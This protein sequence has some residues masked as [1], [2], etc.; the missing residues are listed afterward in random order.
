MIHDV[1]EYLLLRQQLL[2][3]T[4]VTEYRRA[5][6]IAQNIDYNNIPPNTD[7]LIK[8][9]LLKRKER[10]DCILLHYTYEKQFSRYKREIHQI[11]DDTFQNTPIQATTLIVGSRN[12]P[13]ISKELIRRNPFTKTKQSNPK[14]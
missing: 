10:A 12:N 2:N 1:N 8:A 7:P 6:R 4:T 3:E 13:N 5:A 11:W 9:K 14:L